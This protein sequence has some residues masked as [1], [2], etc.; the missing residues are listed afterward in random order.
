VKSKVHDGSLYTHA[1]RSEHDARNI[2]KREVVRQ[3]MKRLN[4]VCFTHQSLMLLFVKKGKGKVL[5]E[6]FHL[7]KVAE[8]K[9]SFLL[10]FSLFL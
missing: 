8:C 1:N 6:T 7:D 2:H 3:K 5:F 9:I 10:V 4:D